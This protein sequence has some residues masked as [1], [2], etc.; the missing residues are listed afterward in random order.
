MNISCCR[1]FNFRTT[2]LLLFFALFACSRIQAQSADS[3][4]LRISVITCSPGAELY[5]TFG[6]TAIR[7]TD[8]A[9]FSDIVFNY[10]TFDFSDPDFYLKF[11][12]GKLN[13]FLSVESYSDFVQCYQEEQRSVTE[14][15]LQL[16]CAEKNKLYQALQLNLQGS[17]RY[18]KYD[19]LFDNCTTRVRDQVQ[20]NSTG[21]IIPGQLTPTHTTF[22]NMIHGY[23]D[24]GGQ[25][26]SKLGIDVLL[27]SLLDDTV[28]LQQSMFLPDYLEKGLGTAV[29]PGNI[30]LVG[31]TVSIYKASP[32]NS[33]QDRWI[34]LLVFSITSFI[35]LLLSQLKSKSARFIVHLLDSLILY[36][37]GL[38]GFLLLF[39][40]F[41]TE[42][43]LC[44]YNYN[45]L[46]ALPT[47]FIAAFFIWK[48]PLWVKK[49]FK[50]AGFLQIGLLLGWIFLPQHLNIALVPVVLIMAYRCFQLAA[51]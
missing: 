13:Y 19:F 42:H 8:S 16:T 5:S 9:R 43:H 3:C 18:Y 2:L 4:H 6:H 49:Y 48:R 28:T 30:P 40:W 31:A 25:P 46:W 10:G 24:K 45:L 21:F 23:L 26:W 37:T 47:H 11:V 32:V 14:Q 36:V 38:A 34:P 33:A 20:N 27:G 29:T 39:M 12:R 41:G 22:R 50:A 7:I 1:L 15:V 17:N 51:D 35:V 44:S